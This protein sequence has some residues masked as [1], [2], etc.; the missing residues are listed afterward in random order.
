[1][2]APEIL[3][4]LLNSQTEE[5]PSGT[6]PTYSYEVDLYALGILLFE[7]LTG[8]PPHGYLH[9]TQTTQEKC[10]YAKSVLL[11]VNK[12]DGVL[13]IEKEVE[14]GIEHEI[15]DLIRGLTNPDPQKRL[16]FQDIKIHPYFKGATNWNQEEWLAKV[17]FKIPP[18][19]PEFDEFIDF[20][21]IYNF[22]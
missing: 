4:I 18:A 9:P 10:E 3:N 8:T 6:E 20:I 19:S 13:S 12:N 2:M 17:A 21:G 15:A 7:M 1:M 5:S 22:S 14:L 16:S 11:D